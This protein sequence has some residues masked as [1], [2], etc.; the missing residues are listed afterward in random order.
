MNRAGYIDFGSWIRNRLGCCV[1]KIAID[2][3]FTCPNRDGTLSTG[4]C[5]FCNNRAFNPPYC[6]PVKRI[7]EQIEAGKRFFASKHKTAKYLA[8]FQAFSNTYAP[9]DILKAK[10]EEALNASD[11][12]GIVI[13]TRPDCIDRDITDYLAALSHRTFV[14]LEIGVESC[15]D[16][17][18]QRINRRHD[19]ACSSRAINLAHQA[20]IPV[21]AHVILG[22]PGEN[23]QDWL[24]QAHVISSLPI[25]ILKIHQLQIVRGSNLAEIY[26]RNPF[27]LFTADE[28]IEF[29]AKYIRCLRKDIV[30]ER[31]VSESPSS[32]LIAPRWGLKPQVIV[33]R[34]NKLLQQQP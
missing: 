18:L 31:F 27:P 5:T 26:C 13:G 15:N 32:M 34:V 10:Y 28:Y 16:N 12:V 17:T 19:F 14:M 29:L 7:Q 33:D 23:E 11:I 2:A 3:G 24:N 9:I 21:C 30:L 4:G 1:Q 25:D 20:H 22:L 6:N 8:Y